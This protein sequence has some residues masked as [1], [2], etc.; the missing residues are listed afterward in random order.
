MTTTSPNPEELKAMHEA[1][2]MLVGIAE[3]KL[4]S[5]AFLGVYAEVQRHVESSKTAKRRMEAAVAVSDPK[6]FA[7]HKLEKAKKKKEARKRKSTHGEKDARA[8]KKL[9]NQ[10]FLYGAGDD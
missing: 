4:G 9:R 3:S 8:S 7:M 10:A 1:A 6:A 5:A 2:E